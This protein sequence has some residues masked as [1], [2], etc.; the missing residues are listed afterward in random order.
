M[1]MKSWSI[2]NN[3]YALKIRHFGH[4]VIILAKYLYH[5]ESVHYTLSNFYTEHS[6]KIKQCSVI[7]NSSFCKGH[8]FTQCKYNTITV[9]TYQ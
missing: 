9:M 5:T 8:E 7:S 1:S 6:I 3:E 2:L 4:S